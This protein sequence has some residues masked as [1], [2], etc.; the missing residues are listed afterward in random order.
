MINSSKLIDD[1][2]KSNKDVTYTKDKLNIAEQLNTFSNLNKIPSKIRKSIKSLNI[3]INKN[4]KSLNPLIKYSEVNRKSKTPKVQFIKKKLFPYK[5]YLNLVIFSRFK[6][7]Q[8]CLYNNKFIKV[9]NFLVKFL[10]ISTYLI[11]LRQF[12]FIKNN[13]FNR[14]DLFRI[15]EDNKINVNKSK[16]FRDANEGIN[17]KEIYLNK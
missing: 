16:Y 4:R 5:Y 11:L 8:K 2:N 3:N 1:Q 7:Q 15:E 12:Q 13:F 6:T 14:K 9:Y 10:D 17:C